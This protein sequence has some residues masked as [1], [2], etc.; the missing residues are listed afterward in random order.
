MVIFSMKRG[1]ISLKELTD[2]IMVSLQAPS[3][4]GF[5]IDACY[6]ALSTN[7]NKLEALV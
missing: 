1:D 6:V 2:L 5:Q 7:Q 3:Q 4:D